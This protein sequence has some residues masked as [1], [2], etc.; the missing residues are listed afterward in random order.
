MCRSE[1]NSKVV[2]GVGGIMDGGMMGGGMMGAAVIWSILV[3]LALVVTATA[4]VMIA[5]RSGTAHRADR[6]ATA[7]ES[8]EILRSRYA[9]GEIDDEEYRRRLTF[10]GQPS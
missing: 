10:L 3:V 9:K 7:Q 4:L 5:R 6:A 8:R 1:I 2:Q